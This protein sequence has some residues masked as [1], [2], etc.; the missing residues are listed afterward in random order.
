MAHFDLDAPQGPRN[1][2][3]DDEPTPEQAAG[4]SVA[5]EPYAA[6]RFGTG[7][8]SPSIGPERDRGVIGNLAHGDIG[9]IA[10]PAAGAV[11]GSMIPVPGV[12]PAVG[13]ALMGALGAGGFEYLR[14]ALAGEPTQPGRIGT[15]VAGGAA[16]PVITKLGGVALR[17]GARIWPGSAVPLQES[18]LRQAR[19]AIRG[20]P[21]PETAAQVA[22][23]TGDVGAA[24]EAERAAIAAAEPGSRA[25]F[26]KQQAAAA[27]SAVEGIPVEPARPHYEALTSMKLLQGEEPVQTPSIAKALGSV[28]EELAPLIEKWKLSPAQDLQKSAAELEQVLGS[29]VL[30]VSELQQFLQDV[31]TRIRGASGK[32]HGAYAKLY[33]AGE[34]SLKEAATSGSGPQANKLAEAN[35]LYRREQAVKDL[36]ELVRAQTKISGGAPS[37]RADPVLEALTFPSNSKQAWNLQRLEAALS[38]EEF[39]NFS[40]VMKQ[41]GEA[42][43]AKMTKPETAGATPFKET[44]SLQSVL[45]KSHPTVE[46]VARGQN[47]NLGD[48]LDQLPQQGAL[49]QSPLQEFLGSNMGA[50]ELAALKQKLTS[51]QDYPRIQGGN[52][53]FLE[54]LPAY[55]GLGAIGTLAGLAAHTAGAGGGASAASAPL[56][57]LLSQGATRGLKHLATTAGGAKALEAAFTNKFGAGMGTK[58]LQA[59][60]TGGAGGAITPSR[61]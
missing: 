10:M 1:F 22:A 11:A 48:V 39:A 15:E 36:G 20:V 51:L 9:R 40:K 17:G 26:G 44:P 52:P 37:F 12:G 16:A 2:N 34:E 29:K 58:L 8:T 3:L 5:T 47:V 31:G 33:G 19:E 61:E 60:L 45:E 6:Q 14:Q 53:G 24:D 41:L 46:G 30:N 18:V 32:V 42:K 54:R 38:P 50:G 21:L 55:I 49:T 56:A 25:L 4:V 13:S 35:Q 59:L 7:A 43:Y 23:R 28:K 57:I 27:K